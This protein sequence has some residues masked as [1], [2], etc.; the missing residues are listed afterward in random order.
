L[1]VS[2]DWPASLLLVAE[3]VKNLVHVAI[4]LTR[5][6]SEPNIDRAAQDISLKVRKKEQTVLVLAA[7]A[8]F[9]E[10]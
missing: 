9:L 2:I 7:N 1:D 5:A 8:R 10:C 3:L 6:S 4:I